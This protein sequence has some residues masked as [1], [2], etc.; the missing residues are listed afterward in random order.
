MWM[1]KQWNGKCIRSAEFKRAAKCSQCLPLSVSLYLYLFLTLCVCKRC[2]VW[3]A[4]APT[5]FSTNWTELNS[6]YFS[7][8]LSLSHTLGKH[9]SASLRLPCSPKMH[10]R[11]L[12][13]CKSNTGSTSRERGIER[14][15]ERAVQKYKPL[16]CK[17]HS[18]TKLN[19][20]K[21]QTHIHTPSHSRH[22]VVVVAVV[23]MHISL[24]W[25]KN[26]KE[27]P[28]QMR[29]KP[30]QNTPEPMLPAMHTAVCSG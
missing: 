6:F 25:N 14:D 4:H 17:N 23:A 1:R 26:W 16:K 22:P 19:L 28:T 30:N 24:N 29:A 2:Q 12:K 8:C 7:I 3:S 18:K 13:W 10:L 11:Q 21:E 27:K 5:I 15:R 20:F 9:K